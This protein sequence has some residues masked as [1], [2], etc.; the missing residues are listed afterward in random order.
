M[1]SKRSPWLRMEGLGGAETGNG[2]VVIVWARKD[3]LRMK[4]RAGGRE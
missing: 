2:D 1:H 3:K 4:A